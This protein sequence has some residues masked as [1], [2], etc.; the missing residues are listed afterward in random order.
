MSLWQS[1][2]P[3]QIIADI[4]RLVKELGEDRP[5]LTRWPTAEEYWASLYSP[6]AE[7]RRED[8][9]RVRAALDRSWPRILLQVRAALAMER[10]VGHLIA[11]GVE[12]PCAAC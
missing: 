12:S 1:K 9:A 8:L 10:R 2:T 5:Y 4:T 11:T 3:E 6:E 7:R